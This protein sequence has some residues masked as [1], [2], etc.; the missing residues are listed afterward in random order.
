MKSS[1]KGTSKYVFYDDLDQFCNFEIC[2]LTIEDASISYPYMLYEGS[3]CMYG[4]I[5]IIRNVPIGSFSEI[6][7][8]CT[9]NKPTNFQIVLNNL[10]ET[11]IV[12]IHYSEY[13]KPQIVFKASFI[14][15][16]R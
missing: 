11:C 1:T 12:V 13:S 16:K 10:E 5:Y 8:L 15:N 3:S 7:S 4:G 6:M 2:D 9:Q 14:N